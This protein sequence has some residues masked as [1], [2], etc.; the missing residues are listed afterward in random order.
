MKT[1]LNVDQTF[2]SWESA[3]EFVNSYASSVGFSVYF[4]SIPENIGLPNSRVWACKFL[5]C[6]F[7]IIGKM[8]SLENEIILDCEDTYHCHETFEMQKDINKPESLVDMK[9]DDSDYK[10]S[11]AGR[12]G[13]KRGPYRKTIERRK[14]SNAELVGEL[15][16]GNSL[17]NVNRKRGPYKK[18]H[19]MAHSEYNVEISRNE[20]MENENLIQGGG[21]CI[22]NNEI[23]NLNNFSSLNEENK[24]IY[25][26]KNN[27]LCDNIDILPDLS[28]NGMEP[29][30]DTCPSKNHRL[31]ERDHIPALLV[32]ANRIAEE[33]AV[34]LEN[35][36]ESFIKYSPIPHSCLHTLFTAINHTEHYI[37]NNITQKG[38][39]VYQKGKVYGGKVYG[40]LYDFCP[41]SFVIYLLPDGTYEVIYDN[42]AHNHSMLTKTEFE[43]VKILVGFNRRIPRKKPGNVLE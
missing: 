37:Q 1:P 41:F 40:C 28:L 4:L 15:S 34:K 18:K 20:I 19:K 11:K 2:F 3:E 39:S 16:E 31:T 7:K 12:S 32:D 27:F 17:K 6:P 42:D 36:T 26:E 29:P 13:K 35:N 38:F 21:N 14:N 25:E 9:D 8:N 23:G 5:N 30:I 22:E 33:A 10:I 24:L 43:V